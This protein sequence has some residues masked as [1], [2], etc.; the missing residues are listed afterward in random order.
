MCGVRSYAMQYKLLLRVRGGG[1]IRCC[2]FAC[3]RLFRRCAAFSQGQHIVAHEL[4]MRHG[5]IAGVFRPRRD[6]ARNNGADSDAG[7]VADHLAVGDDGAG[8]DPD[9]VTDGAIATAGG[10]SCYFAVFTDTRAVTDTTVDAKLGVASDCCFFPWKG[11]ALD[12]H[13]LKNIHIVADL[14]GGGVLRTKILSAL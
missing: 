2:L 10:L 7:I 6:I 8:A 9:I 5:K 1:A 13:L 11:G 4:L 3:Q 12:A 14:D